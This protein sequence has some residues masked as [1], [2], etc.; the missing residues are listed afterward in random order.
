VLNRTDRADRRYYVKDHLGSIRAVVDPDAS[1]TETDKV[2][3]AR[4]H[5]PFTA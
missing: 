2:V 5:Y 1:G 4:D 3:E